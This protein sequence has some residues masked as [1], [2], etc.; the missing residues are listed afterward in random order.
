MI[1]ESL[2]KGV[3]TAIN[4]PL[5]RLSILKKINLNRSFVFYLFVNFY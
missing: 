1:V 2:Q 3:N 5:Q 4:R